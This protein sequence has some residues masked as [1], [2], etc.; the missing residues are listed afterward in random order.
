MY[1]KLSDL[2]NDL[3]GT[4]INLPV[5]SYGFFLALAFLSGSFILYFELKRKERI[6]QIKPT[7]KKILVGKPVS[8]LLLLV[9]F[10]I[11][12][13]IGFKLGGMILDYD[14]FASR[15]Q[16]F[17]FS[18]KGSWWI[19]IV[20]ALIHTGY[21]YYSNKK[22]ELHTP[23]WEEITVHAYEQSLPIL[24]IAVISGIIGAKVFHWLE[25]WDEFIRDPLGAL[26]SFSGLT[27][28]GGLICGVIAGM[29]YG[30]KNGIRPVYLA[31]AVAP[32]L[33]FAYGVGRIG[34]QVAGDGD[35]GIVNLNPKPD[36][37]GF[38]PD[39][40]WAFN[41]PH[42]II[43]EGVRIEGCVAEHCYELAEPVYPT[44]AYETIMAFAIFL[45][46][47]SIRKRIKIP[48]LLFAIYLMFNGAER[49]LIEKI[50][51][52]NKFD[53]LG[54][55]VTQAEIISSVIFLSGLVFAVYLFFHYRKK[56]TS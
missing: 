56:S 2:I 15:P 34:C 28:Y 8:K 27:F 52:N 54:M 7:V 12:L 16:D 53:F 36:W 39:W 23:V 19:G 25:N 30:N 11:S 22:K 48:G 45:F 5:Q 4:D 17:I 50:R 18:G 35:W 51:V 29:Y 37:L 38:I 21:F 32:S 31:D 20:I 3:L 47:W 55:S 10:I 40:L 42:N 24:F 43:N 46:L 44:A 1:P 13:I 14:F 26:V 49:F 9:N 33:I 6:G 41:F